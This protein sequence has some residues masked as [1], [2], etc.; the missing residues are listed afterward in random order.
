MVEILINELDS[1][2]K[3][4]EYSQINWEVTAQIEKEE[5]YVRFN[6]WCKDVGIIAPSIRYPTA[7]GPTGS[8]VGL[9]ETRRIG[10]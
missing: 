10:F 3:R 6:Q 1:R 9:S 7:F 5:K 4:E 2:L 8:L